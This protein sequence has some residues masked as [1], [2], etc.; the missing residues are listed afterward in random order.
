MLTN[1]TSPLRVGC[2]VN[3]WW[4]SR[5]HD[6]TISTKESRNFQGLELSLYLEIG[7]ALYNV[8]AL[9]LLTEAPLSAKSDRIRLGFMGLWIMIK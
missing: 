9:T 1:C 7:R 6:T 4:K 8:L 3:F 5:W 2:D